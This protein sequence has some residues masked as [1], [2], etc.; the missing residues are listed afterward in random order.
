MCGLVQAHA[1]LIAA[2]AT[3]EEAEAIW[4]GWEADNLSLADGFTAT[5][6]AAPEVVRFVAE[7]RPDRTL[8]EQ[9]RA[10]AAAAG[11]EPGR[12]APGMLK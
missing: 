7:C 2:Q 6:N 8:G 5:G 1:A 10:L 12:F 9:V 11:Q 3:N 4:T